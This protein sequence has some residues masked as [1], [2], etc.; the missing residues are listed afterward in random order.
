VHN[1]S[2]CH[3]YNKDGKPLGVATGKPSESKKPYKRFGGNKSMAFMQIMFKAHAKAMRE[4]DSSDSSNS[5]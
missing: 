3:W 5:E 2:D 1:N 4:Y